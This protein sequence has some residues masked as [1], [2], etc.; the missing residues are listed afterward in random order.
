MYYF[1]C[2]S[3]A[4]QHGMTDSDIKEGLG[5][6]DRVCFGCTE[7]GCDYCMPDGLCAM[8]AEEDED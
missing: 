3:C 5:L 4:M 1:E 6:P 2:P 7:E 8:C